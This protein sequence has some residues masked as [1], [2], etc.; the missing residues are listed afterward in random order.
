MGF[1]VNGRRILR[2]SGVDIVDLILSWA[3]GDRLGHPTYFYFEYLATPLQRGHR[4]ARDNVRSALASSCMYAFEPDIA[5][6]KA[7]VN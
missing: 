6:L 1:E 5:I 3:R 4:F 7:C 2:S